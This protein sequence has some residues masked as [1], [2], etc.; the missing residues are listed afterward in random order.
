MILKSPSKSLFDIY[1][2]IDRFR[3]AESI[4]SYEASLSDAYYRFIGS[5]SHSQEGLITGETIKSFSDKAISFI[6]HILKVI[7]H[8]VYNVL[9]FFKKLL[10]AA[11][12]ASMMRNYSEFYDQHKE[13]VLRNF[14]EYG[15]NIYVTAIP[16]KSITAFNS[17]NEIVLSVHQTVNLLE[18]LD[19]SF[20]Q[21]A[22][23][24]SQQTKSKNRDSN[25]IFDELLNRLRN[26]KNHIT[27]SAILLGLGIRLKYDLQPISLYDPQVKN[28]LIKTVNESSS[29]DFNI[30]KSL[31]VIFAIPKKVI[32]LYLFGHEE[33]KPD[34]IP[35]TS[36]LQMTGPEEFNKLLF[37]DMSKIKSD[38]LLINESVKKMENISKRIQVSGNMFC[39]SLKQNT[40]II[41][42]LFPEESNSLLQYS[43]EAAQE[44]ILP[45][46]PVIS[47]FYL[48][49]SSLITNYCMYYCRHRKALFE[50][51]KLLVQKDGERNKE[52]SE[53]A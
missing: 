3:P 50:S 30:V 24:W 35:I 34:V 28:Y 6:A 36:F 15:S 22:L 12:D 17:N 8:V 37:N 39:E 5:L 26:G 18:E 10:I 48:Y 1:I 49:F 42:K 32:N 2:D 29:V 45:L 40:P 52:I 38:M 41:M 13:T 11:M 9:D 25:T 27:D 46:L 53:A 51:V 14:R 21:R 47:S 43:V 20:K 23:L 7:I 16:P 4:K 31:G 44:L 33:V 19:R